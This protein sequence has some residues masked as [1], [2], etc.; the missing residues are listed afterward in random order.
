[1]EPCRVEMRFPRGTMAI[2]LMEYRSGSDGNSFFFELH[3]AKMQLCTER[4]F[5]SGDQWDSILWTFPVG[6]W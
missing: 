2:Q 1:M 4:D 3:L 6:G 5:I